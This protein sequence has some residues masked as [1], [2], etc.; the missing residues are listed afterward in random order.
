[1]IG[2]PLIKVSQDDA[3]E[4]TQPTEESSRPEMTERREL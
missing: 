4:P 2:V 1:M 3:T